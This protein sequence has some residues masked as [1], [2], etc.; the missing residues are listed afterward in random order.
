MLPVT[1]FDETRSLGAIA[2]SMVAEDLVEQ[3]A[4]LTSQNM[5]IDSLDHIAALDKA[6]GKTRLFHIGTSSSASSNFPIKYVLKKRYNVDPSES[7]I[8]LKVPEVLHFV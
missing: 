2:F 3:N 4:Y 1:V 7:S 6:I 8:S 5:K